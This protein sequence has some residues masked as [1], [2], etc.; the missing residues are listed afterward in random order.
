MP[1]LVSI[2][3]F[4]FYPQRGNIN[5]DSSSTKG[6]LSNTVVYSVYMVRPECLNVVS[7][8]CIRIINLDDVQ[9]HPA[10]STLPPRFRNLENAKR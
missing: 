1:V 2:Q 6:N 7:E 5:L 9:V 3:A 10:S 8:L 4:V